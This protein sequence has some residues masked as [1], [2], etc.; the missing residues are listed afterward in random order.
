MKY[1]LFK[2]RIRAEKVTKIRNIANHPS[3][4]HPCQKLSA[5]ID[6]YIWKDIYINF[7]SIAQKIVSYG[8]T[9]RPNTVLMQICNFP[10]H[11]ISSFMVHFSDPGVLFDASSVFG[12]EGIVRSVPCVVFAIPGSRNSSLSP[13]V[14]RATVVRGGMPFLSL[15]FSFRMSRVGVNE[16]GPFVR[17]SGE[18]VMWS[19]RRPLDVKVVGLFLD[20]REI[21]EQ[22]Q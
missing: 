12:K 10:P 16:I 13:K 11:H 15:L 18:Q 4:D 17:R 2:I 22:A 5:Q 7:P 20:E 19:E 21:P 9:S 8:K 3:A 6:S 14:L 1:Q